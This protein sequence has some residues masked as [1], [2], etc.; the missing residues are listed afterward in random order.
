MKILDI[1]IKDM[2]RSF[3]SVF[4]MG[5]MF[6]A[7][8]LITG[9]IYFAFGGLSAGTGRYNLPTLRIAVVNLDQPGQQPVQLGKMLVE[10]LRDPAM[11]SWFKVGEMNDEPGA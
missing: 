9:L 11:P 8:L 2:V 3:R 4:G 1:A 10:F 6:A 7:P 5:M